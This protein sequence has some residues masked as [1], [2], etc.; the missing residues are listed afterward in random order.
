MPTSFPGGLDSLTNPTSGQFLNNPAH[1]EQHANVNDAI[2]ALETK[3]GVDSSAVTT[4]L[5]YKV[6]STSSVDP[7]HKHTKLH[8][9]SGTAIV[10]VGT[11]TRVT[12]QYLSDKFALTDAATIAVDWNNGNVQS[13]T[14]GGNRTVTFANPISGGRYV[15]VFKQD[16]T[17]SRTITWPTIKWQGGAAPT[18]TTTGNK[19]DLITVIYDGTDYF[20]AASLNY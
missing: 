1:D 7:G 4:T 18:L 15:L 19:T 6:K 11:S 5:D 3:V 12:G 20:G 8:N 16:A 10:Q 17:G 13:V 14:L 9:S 2:E